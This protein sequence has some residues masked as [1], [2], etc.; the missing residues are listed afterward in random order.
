MTR[1]KPLQ[2]AALA[3][4]AALL[5][6]GVASAAPVPERGMG[7][8]VSV[9]WDRLTMDL[10]NP[11]GRVNTFK[12]SRS[13]SVK[14]T[15]GAGFFRSP[16]T[17]DLRPPMYVWYVFEDGAIQSF[18]VREL[19]F[20]PGNEQ[21]ASGR[22]QQG[23]PRTVTGRLTAFDE[24]VMQIELEIRGVKETFQLVRGVSMR[25]LAAGQNVQLKTEWSGLQELVSDLRIVGGRR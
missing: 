15:D 17:R 6:G 9:D 11:Q 4:A 25:G 5:L 18:D 21:S 8:I 19:G 13:A 23:V 3:V 20:T 10:K 22:K 7:N 24:N 14:F 16:S 1:R 12:F 2:I